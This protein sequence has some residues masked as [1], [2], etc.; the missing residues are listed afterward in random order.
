MLKNVNVSVLHALIT[1]SA[2]PV[3]SITKRK[4]ICHAALGQWRKKRR[5]KLIVDDENLN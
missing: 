2:A 1:Q 4:E 5:K 3:F